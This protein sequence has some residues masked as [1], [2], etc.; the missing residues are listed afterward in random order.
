MTS[1]YLLL[2]LYLFSSQTFASIADYAYLAGAC[3]MLLIISLF[4]RVHHAIGFEYNNCVSSRLHVMLAATTQQL[5]GTA[6]RTTG[7][8]QSANNKFDIDHTV[9]TLLSCV[10]LVNTAY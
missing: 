9:Y 8:S 1:P 2:R 7:P 3:T 10:H 5:D 6:P 4:I